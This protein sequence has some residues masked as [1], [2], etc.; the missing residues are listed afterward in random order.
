MHI[1]WIKFSQ[2]LPNYQR[3]LNA[4]EITPKVLLLLLVLLVNCF[5]NSLG[6]PMESPED[7]VD[8]KSADNAPSGRNIFIAPVVCPA[9]QML[10][11]RGKCRD[12]WSF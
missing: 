3:I 4:M 12:V 7:S 2:F 9:G 5:S 1:T 11:Y 10:D 6:A 8:V